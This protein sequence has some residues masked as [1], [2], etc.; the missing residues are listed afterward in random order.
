MATAA[1]SKP[2]GTRC[3][4][5]CQGWDA[6]AAGPLPLSALPSARIFL[7]P[8]SLGLAP[9]Q[10]GSRSVRPGSVSAVLQCEVGGMA[11][12]PTNCL[13]TPQGLARV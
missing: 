2:Q 12:A 5:Q 4:W 11:P 10:E 1:S 13:E 8:V 6:K 9:A 3:G 7:L